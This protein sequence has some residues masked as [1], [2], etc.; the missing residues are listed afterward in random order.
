MGNKNEL[1]IHFTIFSI[2][3]VVDIRSNTN[4]KMDQV[5]ILYSKDSHVNNEYIS[6]QV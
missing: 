6:Q 5:T 1:F 3:H 4:D 2:Y